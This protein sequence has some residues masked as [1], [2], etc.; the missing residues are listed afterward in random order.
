VNRVVAVV[1]AACGLMAVVVG[2]AGAQGPY[3]RP[4]TSPYARP[5]L[6]PHLNLLHGGSPAINYYGL[7]RPQE[8]FNNS[9]QEIQTEIH[10]TQSGM[11]NP[12]VT[13]ALP[14]TGH[15]T[16]F[17]SHG[18]YFFTHLGTGNRSSGTPM[19][20]VVSGRPGTP[21]STQR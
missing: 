16:R 10:A 13:T 6:S 2:R 17:F 18:S 14:V 11:M 3:V 7:V 1:A 12:A 5:T 4:Q 21:V 19:P 9:I 20:G 8:E 15:P